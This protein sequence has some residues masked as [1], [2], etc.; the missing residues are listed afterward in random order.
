MIFVVVV[1]YSRLENVNRLAA[2]NS[3]K[4]RFKEF[5]LLQAGN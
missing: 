2:R 5:V 1:C 3:T 4:T